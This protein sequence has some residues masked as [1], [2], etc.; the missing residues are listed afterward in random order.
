MGSAVGKLFSRVLLNGAAQIVE[1]ETSVQCAGPQRQTA[2]YIYAI[3][4]TFDLEREW[5]SQTV[6]IKLDIAKAFDRLC[7]RTF[8]KRLGA[9]MNQTEEYRCWVNMFR[10]NTALLSTQWDETV[11]QMNQGVKQGA[12]ES[13]SFFAKVME[14]CY[15]EAQERFYWGR[16]TT[17]CP[18][19]GLP[20]VSFMDDGVLLGGGGAKVASRVQ[21]LSVILAEWGLRLNPNK[22]KVYFSPYATVVE[23][24]VDGKVVP[25]VQVLEVMGLPMKVEH[26]PSELIGSPLAMARAKLWKLQH[27][28]RNHT[29]LKDRLNLCNK[30]IMPSAMWCACAI[31]PDNTAL[32]LVNRHLMRF[33]CWM[34]RLK[35]RPREGWL[36][37]HLRQLRGAREVVWRVVK[38]RWSTIWLRRAWTFMGHVARGMDKTSPPA[39]SVVSLY[40]NKEWWDEQ[41]RDPQGTRHQHRFYPKLMNW[42]RDMED[43]C[44][45]PWR[46]VARDRAQWNALV[47]KWLGK[48]DVPWT[49]GLQNALTEG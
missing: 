35:R 26:T 21:E 16:D 45:R 46:E 13:P 44:G 9:K 11:F 23:V 34:M 10:E 14:W 43:T 15:T 40:R 41:K 49:S 33:V 32:Q 27:L 47:G 4:K 18:G 31:V 5:H 6:W 7:C 3:A 29:P 48:K 22:C 1:H 39:C 17:C 36:E 38:T 30:L 42:E 8:L 12:V 20:G 37:H 19:L 28:F 2:D 25:Q 24:K